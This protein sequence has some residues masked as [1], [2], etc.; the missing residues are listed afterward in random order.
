MTKCSCCCFLV[1]QKCLTSILHSFSLRFLASGKIGLLPELS[2]GLPGLPRDLRTSEE[3]P[4]DKT[5][6]LPHAIL[7]A[8]RGPATFDGPCPFKSSPQ[9]PS[10]MH[11]KDTIPA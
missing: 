1:T 11:Q 9:S 3:A 8:L 5:G 2:S 7:R 10:R 6:A 4:T